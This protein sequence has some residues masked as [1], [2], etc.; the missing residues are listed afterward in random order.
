LFPPDDVDQEGFGTNAE[1]L[2]IS[3]ALFDRYL[4][5]ANRVSRLAVGDPDI[6]AGFA[7]TTY[8][9]PRLLYQ[10]D[11][12]DEALPLLPMKFEN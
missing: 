12:M 5:S 3:P 2:S 1:A 8:P 4:S 10:G 9:T 11:R 6:G 7:A